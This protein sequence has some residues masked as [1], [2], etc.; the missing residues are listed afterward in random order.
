MIHNHNMDLSKTML[1]I[2]FDGIIP[3]PGSRYTPVYGRTSTLHSGMSLKLNRI[4]TWVF[5]GHDGRFGSFADP[6]ICSL[7]SPS[8]FTF[9]FTV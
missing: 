3:N 9:N 2:Q 4:L 7:L 1:I 8:H 6:N 5:L